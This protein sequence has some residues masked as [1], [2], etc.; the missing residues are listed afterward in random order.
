VSVHYLLDTN[1]ISERT[2]PRPNAAVLAKLEEH[3]EKCAV[4][5]PVWH[6]LLHGCRRMPRGKRR[7]ELELYL[8]EMVEPLLPI[9][10]YDHAAA[11]WHAH[12]R[13]R[14]DALGKPIPFIDGQIASI[15]A[16]N[17]LVL[18]THNTK[19]FARFHGI[20]IV[21]WSKSPSARS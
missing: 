15:A 1:V 13:A 3:Y 12:E 10:P 11:T 5:A 14:L 20:E 16:T 4:A 18:V 21:D 8:Q 7:T 6:E 17:H 2:L 9:L 19:D